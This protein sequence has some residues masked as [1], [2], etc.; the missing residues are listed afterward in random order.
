MRCFAVG[1]LMLLI[2]PQ[3][4]AESG[5]NT[6]TEDEKL[7][8]FFKEYLDGEFRQRPLEATRLGDHRF[9]HLLDDVSPKA[10]VAWTKQTRKTLADLPQRIDYKK[11]S[12]G[13]QIDLEI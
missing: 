11:L 2:G 13:G 4:L 1:L 9:D 10:R 7:T 8:A 6:P 12:R 3:P 5:P